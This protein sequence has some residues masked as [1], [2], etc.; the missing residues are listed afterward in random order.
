MAA[1]PVRQ[2]ADGGLEVLLVTTRETRRWIPPKGWPMKGRKPY[3]AAAI[4]AQEEA[5]VTG[6]ISKTPVG[7]YSYGKR[8][9]GGGVVP[10]QVAVY[11]LAVTDHLP[12]WRE[13]GQR[14]VQWVSPEVAAMLVEEPELAA[15]ILDLARSTS[16][17]E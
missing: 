5:G 8:L 7:H 1:L 4:E 3:R 12:N 6:Q 11:V 2:A 15:L 16:L 13:Q 10:C 14:D 17:E 9:A